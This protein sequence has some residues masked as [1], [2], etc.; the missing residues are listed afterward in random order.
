[1]TS[2]WDAL[3]ADESIISLR[4]VTISVLE[5]KHYDGTVII[6]P[7]FQHEFS[8]TY[9]RHSWNYKPMRIILSLRHIAW[10]L[11]QAA[12]TTLQQPLV[13]THKTFSDKRPKSFA[14]HLNSWQIQ[15]LCYP[16]AHRAISH[17]WP[18]SCRL[19][20]WTFFSIVFCAFAECGA[21]L[22][23]FLIMW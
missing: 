12:L 16:T 9:V 23:K 5:A 11:W 6:L 2:L 7:R 8:R 15:L 10:K 20:L 22:L 14:N 1:M 17:V 13:Q 19:S 4:P 3:T 18:H 21:V